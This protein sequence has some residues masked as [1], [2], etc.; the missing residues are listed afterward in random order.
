[1]QHFV[2]YSC[3][4]LSFVT[5]WIIFG[6]YRRTLLES[7]DYI[8]PDHCYQ[9][10]LVQQCWQN[11][12]ASSSLWMRVLDCTWQMESIET[13]WYWT[14]V[15]YLYLAQSSEPKLVLVAVYLATR[16]IVWSFLSPIRRF[17]CV[18]EPLECFSK[19]YETSKTLEKDSSQLWKQIFKSG[20]YFS[21]LCVWQNVQMLGK[22]Q[23]LEPILIVFRHALQQKPL[24]TVIIRTL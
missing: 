21:I 2:T 3:D 14:S 23:L 22:I 12:I 7:W 1:M 4:I 18:Y 5:S 13:R 6:S 16:G 17:Y 8:A 11:E 15:T 10:H 20:C 24:K 19:K 9:R